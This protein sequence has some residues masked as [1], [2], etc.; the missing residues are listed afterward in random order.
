MC[1]L[2]IMEEGRKREE[3]VQQVNRKKKRGRTSR[4]GEAKRNKEKWKEGDER[5]VRAGGREMWEKARVKASASCCSCCSHRPEHSRHSLQYS[6]IHAALP[7]SVDYHESM[8]K[9]IQCLSTCTELIKSNH[10]NFYQNRQMH[11]LHI[12]GG[13]WYVCPSKTNFL[14]P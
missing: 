13:I 1:S 14:N 2:S 9:T 6:S 7:T 4:K 3:K 12:C 10:S 5:G 11:L 8:Q